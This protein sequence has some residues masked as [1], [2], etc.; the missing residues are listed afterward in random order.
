MRSVKFA[1]KL[2]RLYAALFEPALWLQDNHAGRMVDVGHLYHCLLDALRAR[3]DE[4]PP[5]SSSTRIVC[6]PG[7]RTFGFDRFATS[8]KFRGRRSHGR[9]SVRHTRLARPAGADPARHGSPF[10]HPVMRWFARV[11]RD[12]RPGSI[13]QPIGKPGLRTISSEVE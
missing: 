7:F 11:E 2:K 8:H 10:A 13:V 4:W 9:Q 6:K 1:E 12:R 3:S 5:A